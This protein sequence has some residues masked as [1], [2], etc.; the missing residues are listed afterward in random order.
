MN[1]GEDA[2]RRHQDYMLSTGQWHVPERPPSSDLS[3]LSANPISDGL[4]ALAKR[5]AAEAAARSSRYED[6]RRV[7]GRFSW[8]FVFVY[9]ITPLPSQYES[10][11][12]DFL[13]NAVQ[14]RTSLVWSY[15]QPD[16]ATIIALS[17]KPR[18]D[19]GN[20]RLKADYKT[21][22][23]LLK[24]GTETRA[25]ILY[26]QD[27]ALPDVDTGYVPPRKPLVLLLPDRRFWALDVDSVPYIDPQSLVNACLRFFRES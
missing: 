4:A 26:G 22:E 10:I 16:G 15:G 13:A 17:N 14:S 9:R 21:A 12:A 5:N 20:R 23:K 24:F 25:Y 1:G 2:M 8:E 11:V 7:V 6:W 27:P 3:P 18:I 19:R